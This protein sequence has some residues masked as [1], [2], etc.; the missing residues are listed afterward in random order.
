MRRISGFI[1]IRHAVFCQLPVGQRLVSL[2]KHAGAVLIPSP[3]VL[4]VSSIGLPMI[5]SLRER[6]KR[7]GAPRKVGGSAADKARREDQRKWAANSRAKRL[8]VKQSAEDG[9]GDDS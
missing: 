7:R 6:K 9:A 5:L 2:N 1:L 3:S 8:K 4:L